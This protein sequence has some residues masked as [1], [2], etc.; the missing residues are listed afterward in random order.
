M[1]SSL[2]FQIRQKRTSRLVF[3]HQPGGWFGVR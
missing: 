1:H 2:I 3:I